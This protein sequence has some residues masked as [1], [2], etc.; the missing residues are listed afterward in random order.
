MTPVP[1]IAAAD[2]QALTGRSSAP[3]HIVAAIDVAPH[4][5]GRLALSLRLGTPADD[6]PVHFGLSPE[7]ALRLARDLRAVARNCLEE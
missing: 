6:E 3:G 1:T 4:P 2:M 7:A 5:K